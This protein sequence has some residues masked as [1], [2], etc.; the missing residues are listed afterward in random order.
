MANL[1]QISAPPDYDFQKCDAYGRLIGDKTHHVL[2]E[3]LSPD[4]RDSDDKV[5]QFKAKDF[6]LGIHV[7]GGTTGIDVSL[8]V[9]LICFFHSPQDEPIRDGESKK[10]NT[11]FCRECQVVVLS[12]GIQKKVSEM[13]YITKIDPVSLMARVTWQMPYFSFHPS[14]YPLHPQIILST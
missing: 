3:P 7:L 5:E 1:L 6:V 9:T 4:A 13:K 14:V 8:S 2:V 12:Q 10:S 11:R